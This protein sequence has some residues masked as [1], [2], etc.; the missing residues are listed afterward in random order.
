MAFAREGAKVMVSDLN[1]ESGNETVKL[2]KEA[3]GEAEFFKWLNS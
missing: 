1:E 2:I 3:G